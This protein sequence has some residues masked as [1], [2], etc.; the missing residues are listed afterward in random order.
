[1]ITG[2]TYDEKIHIANKYLIPKQ[3]KANGLPSDQLYITPLAIQHIASRYTRE[4][5]VRSLERQIGSVVRSKAVEWADAQEQQQGQNSEYTKTVDVPDLEAILGMEWWDPEERDRDERKGV[6][7]G[8]VVKGEGEGGILSVETLL[9]PGSG[10]LRLTG[11]LGEVIKESGELAL[12]WVG[13]FFPVLGS[14]VMLMIVVIRSSR[15]LMHWVSPIRRRMTHFCIQ[16]RWM[17]ICIY[18]LVRRRRTVL[19]LASQ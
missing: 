18:L 17:C 5:G 6:V 10:K 19:V 16:I 8:M 12:S 4:A 15:T 9:V 7:Y 14:V 2:Y 3:L 11:S 1:M 13:S